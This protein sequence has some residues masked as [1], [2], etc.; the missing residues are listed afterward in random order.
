[1]ATQQHDDRVF[2]KSVEHRERFVTAIES[3]DD[4][5]VLDAGYTAGVYILSAELGLWMKAQS[6]VRGDVI[7]MPALVRDVDLSGGY[8]V[9]VNL[10][11]NLF[12]G[13]LHLDP[14]ELLRL[15]EGN[16][17]VALTAIQ[18]RRASLR[19]GD[20]VPEQE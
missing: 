8:S 4:G 15:D 1:M 20:F 10:A 14:L 17:K 7:A 2:F 11:G 5:G 6:Y 13:G 3:V 18:M 9:L 19:L 16:F 12:N